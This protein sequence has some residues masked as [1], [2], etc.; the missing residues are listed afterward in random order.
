MQVTEACEMLDAALTNRKITHGTHDQEVNPYRS[1][2]V[3]YVWT[4]HRRS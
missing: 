2:I 1:S 4:T 3:Y